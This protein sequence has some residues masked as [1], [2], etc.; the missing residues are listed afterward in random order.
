MPPPIS[1]FPTTSLWIRTAIFTLLKILRPLRRRVAATTSG[2][3]FQRRGDLIRQHQPLLDLRAS[4]TAMPN[5]PGSISISVERRSSY[6][7]SIEEAMDWTSLSR[8]VRIEQGGD[9]HS[10]LPDQTNA[11]PAVFIMAGISDSANT[12]APNQFCPH[13][14]PDQIIMS[15]RGFPKRIKVEVPN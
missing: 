14:S 15:A 7:R 13:P 11:A 8:L 3:Q 10:K 9:C 1:S 5:Q 4:P 6:M 12:S 2:S